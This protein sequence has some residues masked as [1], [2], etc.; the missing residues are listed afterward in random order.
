M[1][2]VFNQEIGY[3]KLSDLIDYYACRHHLMHE[4][5]HI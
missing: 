5:N 2:L 3:S 4:K 1:D